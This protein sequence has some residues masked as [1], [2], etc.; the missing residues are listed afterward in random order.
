MNMSSPRVSASLLCALSSCQLHRRTPRRA[1]SIPRSPPGAPFTSGLVAPPIACTMR[2][3]LLMVR[4]LSP[5]G[6][7]S[8]ATESGQ[9]PVPRGRF[10]RSLVWRNGDRPDECRCPI[11]FWRGLRFSRGRA[12]A[13]GW[14][15]RSGGNGQRAIFRCAAG[16]RDRA[17]STGW[18]DRLFVWRRGSDADRSDRHADKVTA[19][20]AQP[21]GKFVVAGMRRP[22]AAVRYHADGSLDTG[23]GDNG[24]VISPASRSHLAT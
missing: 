4:S 11:R 1:I 17:L 12:A 9:W 10:A 5:A 7:R 20:V 6:V 16:L 19:L 8:M 23:F 2:P 3:W 21:D 15:N 14:E 18:F 22:L 13:G 24:K